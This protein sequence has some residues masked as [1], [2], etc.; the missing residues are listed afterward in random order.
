MYQE[1]CRVENYEREREPERETE[2]DMKGVNVSVFERNF[3]R[4]FIL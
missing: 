3:G 1:S 4:K 2:R